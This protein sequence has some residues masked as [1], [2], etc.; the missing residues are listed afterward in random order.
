MNY[1]PHNYKKSNALKLNRPIVNNYSL[2]H[3]QSERNAVY[4]FISI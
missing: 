2:S 3:L 4:L 1:T